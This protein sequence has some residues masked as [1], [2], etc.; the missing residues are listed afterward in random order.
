MVD[1]MFFA[2][3]GINNV[4]CAFQRRVSAD[5]IA[6]TITLTGCRNDQERQDAIANR[7]KMARQCGVW[8]VAELRQVHG[9]VTIFD[10]S[11]IAPDVEPEQEADGLTS[12]RPGLGLLIKT[13]DCQPVL[14][15]HASGKYVAALHV[16]WRGN[17]RHYPFNGVRAFCDHYGLNPRDVHAVRGPS[18]GPAAARFT[19]FDDEWGEV[20]RPWYSPNTLTMDLWSLTRN[21]LLRAGVPPEHIYSLDLCTFTLS[22]NFFS[23][24][25][26]KGPGR[27]GNLI[28]IKNND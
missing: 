14:L 20:Y 9:D 22:G 1:L 15:A 21:Q 23:H 3:P 6:D 17:R 24:R 4:G 8:A 19:A 10:A 18:L 12:T 27:Q 13:A 25:R 5:P 16:G 7:R 26:D 2:F 28:W 11:P